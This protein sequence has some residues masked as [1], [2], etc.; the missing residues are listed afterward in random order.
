MDSH[1]MKACGKNLTW[2]YIV[3]LWLCHSVKGE[4]VEIEKNFSSGHGF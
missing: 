2:V 3:R 4:I 1:P